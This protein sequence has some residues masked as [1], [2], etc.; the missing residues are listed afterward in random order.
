MEVMTLLFFFIVIIIIII[1]IIIINFFFSVTYLLYV[2]HAPWLQLMIDNG[3]KT[4]WNPIWSVIM[5]D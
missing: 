1:I 4:E 2:L 3:T 5:S